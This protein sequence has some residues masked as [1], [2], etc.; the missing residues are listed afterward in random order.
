MS[1]PS[2]NTPVNRVPV[3]DSAGG[4]PS[5]E[6]NNNTIHDHDEHKVH[7]VHSP[8]SQEG[9]ILPYAHAPQ[10]LPSSRDT[11]AVVKEEP[12]SDII[13]MSSQHPGKQPRS[14]IIPSSQHGLVQNSSR[15]DPRAP[16]PMKVSRK[17]NS[18]SVEKT[19]PGYSLASRL[20]SEKTIMPMST[21]SVQRW[22]RNILLC[23]PRL[24][25]TILMIDM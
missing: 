23:V 14:S 9:F 11:G 3:D 13:S 1:L 2:R 8:T 24:L 15:P 25:F 6:T 16:R 22:N 4:T 7:P 19:P 17:P 10:Y 12:D 18:A 5:R 21:A 20:A